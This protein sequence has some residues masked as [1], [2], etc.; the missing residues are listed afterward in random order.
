MLRRTFAMMLSGLI[1]FTAFGFGHVSAQGG[2]DQAVEKV[3]SKVQ[4]IGTGVNARVEVKLQDNSR[5]K[6]YISSADQDSFTV[7]DRQT[8]TSKTV[9]YADTSS[10]KKAGG[11]LSTKT[12]II[13]GAT[14][15][16]AAV[17]W[18]LVKPVL[19]DGGAQSRGPC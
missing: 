12:W 14:A 1:L 10:V 15:V 17:T 5:Y 16:G 11:G 6:G 4:K 18:V 2:K 3:R 9:S 8:G 7:V 13:L 19:C